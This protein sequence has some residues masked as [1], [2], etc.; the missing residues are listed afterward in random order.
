MC[1]GLKVMSVGVFMQQ[2]CVFKVV[3]LLLLM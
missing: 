1:M 2:G 3:C